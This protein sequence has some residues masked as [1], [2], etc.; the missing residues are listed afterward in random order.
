MNTIRQGTPGAGSRPL[1]PRAAPALARIV[2][3]RV[4]TAV[5]VGLALLALGGCLRQFEQLQQP[6]ARSCS[7]T[8]LDAAAALHEEAK[9]FLVR[10]FNER[11]NRSLLF[12]YYASQD[13]EELTKSIRYCEDF[14]RLYR[15]RGSNLIRATRILRK[16]VVG[17]MRDP[18]PTVL[19]HL[20]GPDY[21]DVFRSD[22]R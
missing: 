11:D 1:S 18:D 21:D 7:E 13:T 16:V 14:D 17:N 6:Q 5:V 8:R 20:M 19:V 12:A 3:G 2:C 10:H 22:I 4:V 9:E 15:E